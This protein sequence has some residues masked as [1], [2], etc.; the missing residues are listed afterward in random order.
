LA[1]TKDSAVKTIAALRDEFLRQNVSA[2]ASGEV[3]RAASRFAVVAAA[4]ELAT[5]AGITGWRKDEA[6]AAASTVFSSW[7]AGRGTKGSGDDETIIRQVRAFIE[8][9]GASRFLSMNPRST[10]NGSLISER[11]SNRAG[12]KAEKGT[13]V[14]TYFVLPET[15]RREVCAGFDPKAVAKVLAARGHLA[16][17]KNRWDTKATL[18]EFGK[19]RVYAVKAT[20]MGSPNT[21]IGTTTLGSAETTVAGGDSGASGDS[22]ANLQQHQGNRPLGNGPMVSAPDGAAGDSGAFVTVGPVPSDPTDASATGDMATGISVHCIEVDTQ[23]V[24]VIPSVPTMQGQKT[25]APDPIPTM[26]KN[27]GGDLDLEL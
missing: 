7:M 11:V 10:F 5:A 18:P 20:I 2:G 15:F 25:T 17:D 26:S 13:E 1:S 12:Y 14:V 19:T 6:L 24:P 21:V 22:G 23:G 8:T 16:H 9:H 27:L 3:H 4:G